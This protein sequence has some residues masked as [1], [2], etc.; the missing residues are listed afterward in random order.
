M[1]TPNV[2]DYIT[3]NVTMVPLDYIE[4]FSHITWSYIS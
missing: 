2:C 1:Y 4:P 3:G